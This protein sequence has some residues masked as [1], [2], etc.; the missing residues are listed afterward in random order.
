MFS[1][2]VLKRV[3]PARLLTLTAIALLLF[4]SG[5]KSARAQQVTATE[6]KLV[7]NGLQ[8]DALQRTFTVKGNPL[9]KLSFTRHDLV[10]AQTAV[11]LLSNNVAVTT[12][13]DE[14]AN[15]QV[16]N[17]TVSGATKPGHYVGDLDLNDAGQPE[18]KPLLKIQLDV[19]TRS[20]SAVEADIN[21]KSLTLKLRGNFFP[22]IGHPTPD[23][24]RTTLPVYELY[25]VQSGEQPAQVKDAK[26]L[27]MKATSG[28]DLPAD[29][30]HVDPLTFPIPAGGSAPLKFTAGGSDIR[31][32]STT[33]RCKFTSRTRRR[34][35]RYRSNS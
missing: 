35:Y 32:G 20:A 11:V 10:D 9:P 24:D 34:R 5:T 1:T 8:T 30:V 21:S 23:A 16:F 22:F 4:S 19:T 29:I 14:T 2:A 12:T 15:E 26:V 18:A 25:L 31:A 33:A 28:N 6:T 3:A 27:G 17:V 13:R 7:F